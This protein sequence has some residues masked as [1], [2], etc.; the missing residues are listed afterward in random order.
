V[1]RSNRLLHEKSPYLLQHAYNPVDWYPWGEEAFQRAVAEQK[2][3]FLSSGYST[4]HWC[5]VMARESFTDPEIAAFLNEHFISVKID[6]EERPDVDGVYMEFCRLFTG[7]G[8]WPLSVFLTPDKTPVFAG[9]YFPPYRRNGYPGFLEVLS[10]LNELWQKDP[11]NLKT[12]GREVLEAFHAY[13]RDRE[14]SEE[15]ITLDPGLL[16]RGVRQLAA[17]YDE[18]WGGFGTAPKFPMPQTLLFLFR[19]YR[20]SREEESRHMAEHT[21]DEMA[22]GGIFDHVGG[23]FHR[24]ATDT[25]WRWPHFEK[26]LYDQAL[27]CLAYTEAFQ[28]TGKALYRRVAEKTFAYIIRELRAPEGGFYTAQDAESEGK[29]GKYYLWTR[30]EILDALGKETGEEFCTRYNITKDGNYHPHTEGGEGQ[31]TAGLN[32]LYRQKEA[33][34]M[35]KALEAL[36]ERRKS[37]IPPMIDS[38]ILTAWN[39]LT[40]AALT[41]AAR[42]FRRND[43]LQAAEEAADFLLRELFTGKRLLRRYRQGETAIEGFLDDYAFFAWGL[44]ELYQATLLPVYGEKAAE[45]TRILLE[46]FS[47][48]DGGLYYTAGDEDLPF[49]Q[50]G[51]EEGALPSGAS[52][53]AGNLLALGL[54]RGD[55]NWRERGLAVIKSARP[56]LYYPSAYPYLLSMADRAIG[57]EMTLV[58]TGPYR[59]ILS[60]RRVVDEFY[61]PDLFMV[62]RPPG[63]EG[64]AVAASWPLAKEYPAGKTPRAYLCLNRTCQPPLDN[65]SQLRETLRGI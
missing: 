26:M 49:R 18:K 8:G 39:G 61:L 2:L 11:E 31:G 29:E 32:I 3:I 5:H 40:I 51:M 9:S 4:C 13:E 60:F 52:V 57:P 55:N 27:L 50:K 41:R 7:T 25:R 1:E 56:L 10:T 19:W 37:R 34:E 33:G 20:R 48:E 62:H 23:G 65:S 15:G 6:R 38:K 44:L 53:A 14:E 24:Y 59:E 47:G 58:L 42:V 45:L 21:L 22:A 28:I 12:R 35:E 46:L 36:F 30:E 17:D 43:Y 16:R 64:E 54:M 63:E